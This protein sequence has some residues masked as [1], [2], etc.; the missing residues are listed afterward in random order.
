MTDMPKGTMYRAP[1]LAGLLL[2]VSEH[3]GAEQGVC[4]GLVALALF[5]EP[6]DDVRIEAKSELPLYRAI[7]GIH[8]A[9]TARWRR[10]A[11]G[12][13]PE[14]LGELRD[15][16]EDDR[17]PRLRRCRFFLLGD[18]TLTGWANMWRTYGAPDFLAIYAQP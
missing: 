7:K 12:V 9:K 1:T 5:A 8:R 10:V 11:D 13:A 2:E 18:P 6:S 17:V 3:G 16:G 14:F 4:A 15:V